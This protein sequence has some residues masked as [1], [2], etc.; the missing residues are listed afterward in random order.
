MSFISNDLMRVFTDTFL[1]QVS[2]RYLVLLRKA[3]A[4]SVVQMSDVKEGSFLY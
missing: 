2:G 4:W 3:G 1:R